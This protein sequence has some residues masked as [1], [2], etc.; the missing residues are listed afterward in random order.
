M[1]GNS[2][3]GTPYLVFYGIRGGRLSTTSAYLVRLVARSLET[4]SLAPIL[5]LDSVHISWMS[6]FVDVGAADWLE[7]DWNGHGG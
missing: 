6:V 1:L 4:I 5:G 3:V 2:I 7:K